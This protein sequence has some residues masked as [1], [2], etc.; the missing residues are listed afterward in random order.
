MGDGAV[1]RIWMIIKMSGKDRGED[2]GKTAKKE[3]GKEG[4]V[5]DEE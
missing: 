2:K 5:S 1:D 3:L 4:V